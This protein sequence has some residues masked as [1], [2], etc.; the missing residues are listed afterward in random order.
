[1]TDTNA[2][3][4]AEQFRK[5]NAEKKTVEERVNAEGNKEYLD[6]Q[7][8]EWVS[9]NE[10]KT[11]EKL[12]QKAAKEAE[13]AVKKAEE[14]KDKAKDAK[15][16]KEAE[17]ELDPTKYRENRMQYLDN[18]RSEGINPYPHKFCRDMT[19]Q[20]F[21]DKYEEVKIENGSFQE[22]KIALAGR[23]MGLRASGQKLIFI[24]LVEDNAR[25]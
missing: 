22:E 4:K 14:K 5:Q 16:P 11:R 10:L 1:M 18:L 21:R 7:T 15:G 9:K 6:D 23:I 20:Q 3:D 13:K 24:D 12:R 19:L 25:V 2:V 17:E 8:G